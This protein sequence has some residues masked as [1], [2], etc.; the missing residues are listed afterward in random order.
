MVKRIN[1]ATLSR[2]EP[3]L[4]DLEV[5]A[6]KLAKQHK[7]WSDEWFVVLEKIEDQ[8]QEILDYESAEYELASRY[9]SNAAKGV[10]HG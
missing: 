2:T 10:A 5:A 3:R 1:W 9:L 4:L 6:G 8:L 7:A